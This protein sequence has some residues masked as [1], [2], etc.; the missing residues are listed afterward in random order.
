MRAIPW[1]P[2]K[3]LFMIAG[4]GNEY[5][6]VCDCRRIKASEQTEAGWNVAEP[7]VQALTSPQFPGDVFRIERHQHSLDAAIAIR[8]AVGWRK[9]PNNPCPRL[10]AVARHAENAAGHPV[11]DWPSARLL[12]WA[13]RSPGALLHSSEIEF[14]VHKRKRFEMVSFAHQ[15]DPT[16]VVRTS[17]EYGRTVNVARRGLPFLQKIRAILAIW[18]GCG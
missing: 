1:T 5:F 4:R 12:P 2:S 3:Q 8:I 16:F 10:I 7:G 6:S 11:H 13:W 18:D 14:S 17:P 15:I 9:H